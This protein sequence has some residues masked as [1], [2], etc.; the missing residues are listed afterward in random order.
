M[1]IEPPT[2]PS[3][4][5]GGLPQFEVEPDVEPLRLDDLVIEP[6]AKSSPESTAPPMESG[7][8]PLDL[9]LMGVGLPEQEAPPAPAFGPGV[10]FEQ[11]FDDEVV[12]AMPDHW[13]GTQETY[14][15]AS[16]K[17]A[18]ES[19]ALHSTRCLRF[20]KTEG[21]G[22]AYY[23]CQFPDATGQVA[24][25]FDLRCDKKNKFLLGLY[26]EKD[27]DFR[28]SIHTTIH[29]P[30]AAGNASL[31]IQ[32]EAV[33]YEMGTWRRI[34][35]VVNLTTGRLSGYVNGET[36]LDNI[37]LTKCPRSLNTLS[38]RD[39]ITTTGVLLIDNIQI[40]RV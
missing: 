22:S 27:R 18:D 25:E 23:S 28:Q 2:G 9:D 15:F 40:S 24:I 5:T 12:G 26:V 39:N 6:E 11:S 19:P 38:I 29:Q 7:S 32:G 30:D 16:L 21:A 3:I 34:R 14:S 35:C 20:E 36:V 13:E 17:V 10:F 33:P 37:R 4:A 1:S 31:R 8:T